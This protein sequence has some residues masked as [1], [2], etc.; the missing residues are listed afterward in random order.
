MVRVGISVEGTTEERFV[1]QVL[2]PY[3]M[4]KGVFLT[5]VNLKGDVS[6]DKARSEVK[7]LANS[8]DYVTTLYDFYAFKGK[9]AGESKSSLEDKMLNAIHAS[10][11]PKFIP[12]VQMY[13]FEGLLFSCPDSLAEGLNEPSAKLWSESVLKEFSGQP[14]LINNAYETAPSKRLEKNTGYKKTIHGPLVA[15]I[16]GIDKIRSLCGYFDKWLQ[17]IEALG[18][19]LPGIK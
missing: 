10:I 19:S 16:V 11:Q 8:F 6:V 1:I 14:E 13:E 12:Y 2:S 3:L 18:D 17:A 9:D 15:Q 7:K 5:P 4:Q